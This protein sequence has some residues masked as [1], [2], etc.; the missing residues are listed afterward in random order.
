MTISGNH[1]YTGPTLVTNGTL[2]INGN[3]STSTTTV[4]SG[5]V[6]GGSGTVGSVIVLAGG[7]LTPG[8]SPG[9]LSSSAINL[10]T[11]SLT[12]LQIDGITRGTA[13]D[14]LNVSGN[15]T[16]GGALGIELG[17]VFGTGSYVFDL[18]NFGAET[19]DLS[20]VTLGGLYSG[21][22][23]FDSADLWSLTSGNDTWSFSQSTGD[24]TLVVVPEPQ[25]ALLG[26]LGFLA[27]FRRRRH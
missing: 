12:T 13:Y 22:L 14:G 23:T 25:S 20:A 26:G 7:E 17:A 3:I 8:N 10:N 1:S 19:G 15:L 4:Q 2:V 21:S 6:L 9:V 24:L 18:F 5:G 16:Y 27:L 11:G